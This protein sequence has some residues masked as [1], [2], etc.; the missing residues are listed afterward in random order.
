[1]TRNVAIVAGAS[2]VVG[3]RLSEELAQSDDWRVIGCAR[4]L[5]IQENRIA[6]VDYAAVDLANPAGC[7]KFVRGIEG[8]T[9]LFYAAR[10]EF[11]TG[12]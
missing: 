2:G 9:H 4:R 1:M 7:Q 12:Q 6:G 3:A 5:P 8:V 11:I 10:A